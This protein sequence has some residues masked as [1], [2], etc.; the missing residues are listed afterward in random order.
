MT[1]KSSQAL[2]G[3]VLVIGGAIYCQIVFAQ[4]S[5][6]AL[7]GRE[8]AQRSSRSVVVLVTEDSNGKL[9]SL[10]SGFFVRP[11]VIATNY[12]VVK[13]AARV[14]SKIV[15]QQNVYEVAG[16]VG[17]SEKDDLALIKLKRV[18]F[19]DQL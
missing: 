2:L 8:I 4:K 9:V 15:G 7:S 19:L 12:H 11:D 14:Y 16:L 6:R 5:Q 13:H 1:K 3:F 10:G 17:A 18:S